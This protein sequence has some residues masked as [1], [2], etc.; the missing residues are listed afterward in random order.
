MK[1]ISTKLIPL[2]VLGMCISSCAQVDDYLLGKDNTPTPA[3]LSPLKNKKQLN[4]NWV[5]DTGFKN[6]NTAHLKL[7]PVIKGNTVYIAD[8][9]GVVQ[10]RNSNSGA[11]EWSHR[12]NQPIISGPSIESG[13]VVVSTAASSI[14][15]LN[16]KNGHKLWSG[17]VSGDVLSKPLITHNKV[18]AKT[19]DGNLYAFQLQ[20]G[21]VLWSLEHGAPS[22]IL[23]TSSSPVLYKGTTLLAG[24]SDGKLDAVDLNSGQLLWQRSIAFAN[25]ASDVERLVDIDADPMVQANVVFLASYQ[26]YLGALSLTDGQFI[27]RKPASTYTNL[28]GQSNTLFMVDSSDVIWSINKSTGTVNWKQELLKSRGLTEPSLVGNN[29]VVG[30]KTGIIHII[31][32]KNGAFLARKQLGGAIIIAPA[33]AN[34]K[35]Y[36]MTADGKLSRLTVS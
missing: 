27:W 22:L 6:K 5:I 16:Q 1:T 13:Y 15:V 19:I 18:I 14:V 20:T 32:T 8:A 24:Y 4:L 26:G 28:V 17:N 29:L 25:G 9:G 12:I 10:A 23:K 7:K 34:N 33:V 3:A 31:S 21:K 36:V 2:F 35:I 11:I 30:D